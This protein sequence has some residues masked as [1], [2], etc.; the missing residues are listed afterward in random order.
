MLKTI[1]IIVGYQLLKWIVD[2][3][4]K[5]S[6][7]TVNT[8]DDAIANAAKKILDYLSFLLPTKNK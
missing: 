2:W 5:K 4:V 8:V 6:K 7:Y 1:L 3:F